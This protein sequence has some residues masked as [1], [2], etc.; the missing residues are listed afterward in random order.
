VSETIYKFSP[1]RTV[2]LRGFDRRGSSAAIHHA[3]ATG[4]SA[5]GYFADQDDF[6]VVVLWDADDFFEHYSMKYLPDFDMSGMV[7]NFDLAYTGLQPIDSPK[8]N[9]IDWATLDVVTAAGEPKQVRL[10]DHASLQGGTFTAASGTF[11]FTTSSAVQP[12]DRVTLW[13]QNLAYDFIVPTPPSGGAATVEYAF[14][15]A[16][17][18]TAHTITI[19]SRTY[20]HTESNPLGESSADVANALVALIHGVDPQTD[21]AIGSTS[22]AVLLSVLPAAGGV[23]IPVSATGGV[24]AS[25]YQTTIAQVVTNLTT[26]INGTHWST[27]APVNA[28]MASSASTALTTTAAR[29]G[30][31]STSGA[32]V[33][34]A[35]GV[36]FGG[37]Q[38]GDPFLII[39]RS[40]GAPVITAYT[41]LTCDS[42]TQVTLTGSPTAAGDYLAPRG[43]S[44]G[45]MI[46]MY[47]THKTT[48]LATDGLV[49][50][51]GGSSAST[52]RV[53]IDFSALSINNIRQAWLTLAPALTDSAAFTAG[54]WSAEF[55]N[56]NV[57]D[58]GGKRPLSIAGPGSV[59]VGNRDPWAT[60]TGAWADQDGFYY[61]GFAKVASATSASVSVF[62]SC[63]STHDLF[64]G[65]SLY[66]DRGIVSVSLDGDTAT[67]LD[68]YLAAEPPVN[69]RRLV[70][71]S[72]AAGEHTL[73]I[74]V[75]GRKHVSGALWDGSSSN[76]FFVFDF[77]EA[78]VRSDV[79]P[80]SY[81]YPA[82][83]PAIDYDT[84]H[85]YKLTPQR[86]IWNLY[87][88]G[89][90]GSI[91][92]YTG[93]FWLYQRKRVLPSG[94]LAF[95]TW[96][97]TFGGTWANGDTA[98]L[99]FD[100]AHS[101]GSTISKSVFPQDN[102]LTIANHFAAFLNETFVGVWAAVS[103]TTTTATLTITT[104]SPFFS[105]V[106]DFAK[107]S[108]SGTVSA[109]GDLNLGVEGDWVV[110]DTASPHL[111]RGIRDWTAD[112]YA[113]C[114]A[115]SLLI[116]S[117]ISMEL[118]N[119]PDDPGS[120]AVYA[121]RFQDGTVVKTD[122][123][124]QSLNSTQC[125]FTP[126][127]AAFQKEVLAWLAAAQ[128]AA[129]LQPWLQFGEFLWWF[130]DWYP[131]GGSQHHAGMAFYDAYTTA[132]ASSV[133]GHALHYFDTINDD[134]SLNLT[135]ANFLR[136]QIKAH[137]D[138]LIAW[139]LA[140]TPT[141]KFELLY[142]YDV[143][144]PTTNAFG[145][146][147]R[148][149][150]FVNFPSEYAT[151]AGS[152]LDRLKMESLSFGSQERNLDKQAISVN[153]PCTAPNS[154]DRADTAYLVPVDN[155]GCP[156]P[157]EYL[158]AS[159][160][161][162]PFLSFWAWD[163]VSLFSWPLP[164]PANPGSAQ[165]V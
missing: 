86:L 98:F 95:R 146:G 160:K 79:T 78:A 112:L 51:T 61:H 56:W 62:Y 68:C 67:D 137:I 159:N 50:F 66:T 26:Q 157:S 18:G 130:F 119:P 83:M 163:H 25:L 134:P 4:F 71:S 126:T 16:G 74:T 99:Y 6:A 28:V 94:A 60:Y 13:F 33:T 15:A 34:L 24:S 161:S 19:N 35:S 144:F 123:G 116:S 39:D 57:T 87:T 107:T 27:I 111:A 64:V 121:A 55:T 10:W 118:V 63:Q 149:N 158:A 31:V 88:L 59:R 140:S 138:T 77:L 152:G 100:A 105:F 109:T 150:N 75:T 32:V 81:S 53:S 45:N 8:F 14:F 11:N 46:A 22:N 82:V 69:T 70:R 129:G 91:D 155:G 17:T 97:V 72:V 9:W 113:E 1:H 141:C 90:R 131:S 114:A 43:G 122:T 47:A 40:G 36:R 102:P 108:T 23:S 85:T 104:R 154:W 37:L 7:L 54:E 151:K 148:L 42:P 128:A 30:T 125:A 147:G 2:S 139:V 84:D 165:F 103:G 21:A 49:K 20:T 89:F 92:H 136:E 65:T 80:P 76:T 3:S 162:V 115:K 52:W 48:T 101:A 135:D 156:W 12:F 127:V 142:P 29:Y 58:P 120:G 41:V 96:T 106:P 153:F 133:L 145:I 143:N 93:V 132:Q 73:V 5:S 38:P 124:F 110:D 164:L 117:A 44:D